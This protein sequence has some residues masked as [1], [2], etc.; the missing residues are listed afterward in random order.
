M[1]GLTKE[2][3]AAKAAFL[4]PNDID[5]QI[6]KLLEA[7]LPL[8]PLDEDDEKRYPLAGIIDKINALRAEQAEIAKL[9]G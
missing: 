8:Y 1:A 9:N 2:Q 5:A 6:E 3:R 4:S 7:A